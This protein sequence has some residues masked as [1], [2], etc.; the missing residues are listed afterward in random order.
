MSKPEPAV[1]VVRNDDKYD[2]A[3]K[4]FDGLLTALEPFDSVYDIAPE[5]QEEAIKLIAAEQIIEKVE[6]K[7]LNNEKNETEE[8]IHAG[9][10]FYVNKKLVAALKHFIE[11]GRTKETANAWIEQEYENLIYEGLESD[12]KKEVVASKHGWAA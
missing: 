8:K 2:D 10:I 12:K 4:A 11:N 9:Q 1:I 7:L 3:I 5:D 6:Y